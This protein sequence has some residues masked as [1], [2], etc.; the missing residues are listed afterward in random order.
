[1]SESPSR[2]VCAVHRTDRVDSLP[3][4]TPFVSVSV[5][6]DAVDQDAEPALP[7]NQADVTVNPR[8][9][10]LEPC[11]W[12]SPFCR[13]FQEYTRQDRTDTGTQPLRLDTQVVPNKLQARR[14][15]GGG[16]GEHDLSWQ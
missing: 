11:S 12:R 8:G 4:P 2:P 16:M 10:G 13:G 7:A 3:I 14:L 9:I 15:S 5:C 6:L 1:M